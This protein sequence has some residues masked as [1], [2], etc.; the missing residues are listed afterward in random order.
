MVSTGGTLE[1]TSRGFALVRDLVDCAG[2]SYTV[3]QSS[4]VPCVWVGR[5]AS[6][7]HLAPRDVCGLVCVL[8]TY[9]RDGHLRALLP[10]TAHGTAAA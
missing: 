9:A 4:V 1:W 10:A 6:R 7:M 5:E 3:Q 8:R 2:A